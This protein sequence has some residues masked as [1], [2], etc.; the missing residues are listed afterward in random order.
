M[1]FDWK[2]IDGK[3]SPI[4]EPQPIVERL[5]ELKARLE[6]ATNE[7]RT[8]DVALISA[9]WREQYDQWEECYQ[10]HMKAHR[11]ELSFLC[12]QAYLRIDWWKECYSDYD[13]MAPPSSI[14]IEIIGEHSHDL[15]PK[16]W[17]QASQAIA[18]LPDFGVPML[19][20]PKS[21]LS[22]ALSCY[23]KA[24]A[25]SLSANSLNELHRARMLTEQALIDHN[26]VLS[27]YME[28][29]AHAETFVSPPA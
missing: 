17:K 23:E 10:Q 25:A 28:A 27:R 8:A 15:R 16:T 3:V 9:L 5:D 2:D 11:E 24:S 1:T 26:D 7:G 21:A 19:D 14:Q 12:D 4:H 18:F 6:N 20:D 29:S 22:A 13:P